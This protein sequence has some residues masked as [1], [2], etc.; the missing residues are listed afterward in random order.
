MIKEIPNG[1]GEL[2]LISISGDDLSIVNS[3]R[4][5]Y[6]KRKF[7]LDDSDKKLIKYLI[8]HDHVSTLEHCFITFRARIPKPIAVQ[9]MRHRSWA[10]N[11]QSGRYI[12]IEDEFYTPRSIRKQHESSKQASVE[13]EFPEEDAVHIRNIYDN[14]YQIAHSAYKQLLTKGVAKEQARMVLP[15]GFFTEIWASCNLRSFLHWYKARSDAHAQWEIQ[16]IA[17]TALSMVEDKF[18]VA[19]AAFKEK[20][21]IA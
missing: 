15:F 19:I 12:E 18:P 9:W 21:G 6:G 4:V 5:S 1:I 20:E 3:A 2:E 14:S 17:K 11:E 13:F 10:F 16:E 8:N 7:E